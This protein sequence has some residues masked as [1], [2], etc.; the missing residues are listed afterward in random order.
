MRSNRRWLVGGLLL[1]LFSGAGQTYYIALY[2]G[3]IR[4]DFGLS[5][6]QFGSLYMLATL[7]SA[8]TLVLIGRIVDILP[9][10]TVAA[11]VILALGAACALMA[12]SDSLLTLGAAIY[13]LRL[14][15]QGMMTHTAMTA[16][17]RWFRRERGRAVAVTSAGFQLGEGL[18]PLSVVAL[19]GWLPWRDVWWLSAGLLVGVALPG[20]LLCFS[21]GR[22]PQAAAGDT[23]ETGRQWTRREVI[24]DVPFWLLCTAMLAPPFIS[25]SIFFHQVH[26]GEVKGWA[27]SVLAGSFAV[28]ALA[29]VTAALFAGQLIDRLSARQVLPLFMAPMALACALLSFAS[30]PLTAVVFMGLLGISNGISNAVFGAIWPEIYGTRHLGAIRSLVFAG[31]VFASALGPGV[32]GWL[33][34]IGL[35]FEWQLQIMAAYA[36]LATILLIPLSRHLGQP[37]CPG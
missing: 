15:G 18:M 19:L 12:V 36:L 1:T 17:G 32:T 10:R 31:M 29:S 11:G 7:A 34:D 16:M 20:V 30:A 24:G 27:P 25:T 9:V 37:A 2:A 33:I 21:R 35:G 22:Q 23:H 6:G 26:I 28:L 4:A 3:D 13:C 14:F 5:H 8:A